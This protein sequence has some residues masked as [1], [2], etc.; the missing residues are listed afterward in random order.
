M[1]VQR[2]HAVMLAGG[3]AFGLAAASGAM[4]YLWERGIGF[5][6]GITPVPI[7]PA[8][9]IFDL[10][11]G[12]IDWPDEAMGYDAC[13]AASSQAPVQGCAGA[14]LGA[15]VGKILGNR[16]A[17]KSGVGTASIRVAGVVV[18]ALVVLN[19]FG[20]VVLPRSGEIVAGARRPEDG[21]FVDTASFLR[22]GRQPTS[23]RRE[24]TTLAVVATDASLTSEEANRLAA[25]AHDA[26]AIT[27]RPVHTAVDG[28]LVFTLATGDVPGKDSPGGLV[29]HSAAISVLCRA[30][31]RAVAF[32][33]PLG[34]LPAGTVPAPAIDLTA[35]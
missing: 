1:L 33:T 26:L 17:T 31:L 5:P 13:E 24:N 9:A 14:G 21:S 29:L 22:S 35:D 19:A 30:I 27:I 11:F 12:E 6:T 18:G 2:V 10:G 23:P 25:I 16:W 20:D 32:A 15:S 28:D 7:V 3:S 34:G 8:A 4:R